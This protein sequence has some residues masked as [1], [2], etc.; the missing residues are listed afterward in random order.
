MLANNREA[1][2]L[3]S[4]KARL[5]KIQEA[6]EVNDSDANAQSR[7]KEFW[8]TFKLECSSTHQR[9]SDLIDEAPTEETKEGGDSNSDSIL[10]LFLFKTWPLINQYF[11]AGKADISIL[12]GTS[13]I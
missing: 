7:R 6:H 2:F 1:Q 3:A 4:Q 12:S 10:D 9:L 8:Q 11:Y 13:L 5:S